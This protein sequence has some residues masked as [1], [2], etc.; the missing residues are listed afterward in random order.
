[1]VLKVSDLCAGYNGLSV[2]K[3][4]SLEVAQGESVALLGRNGSGKSTLL[5][6]LAGLHR[7]Y[8]GRVLYK[9]IDLEHQDIRERIRAGIVF[10]PQDLDI[11]PDMSVEENLKVCV[12]ELESLG[13]TA[14][15]ERAFQLCPNLQAKRS[16]RAG[17]LSGG[18]RRLMAIARA[19]ISSA[20][21][22]LLDEPSSG[23]APKALRETVS[24]IQQLRSNRCSIILVEQ[25]VD[26]ALEIADRVVVMEGGALH[27]DFPAARYRENS[28]EV[29]RLLLGHNVAKILPRGRVT[30]PKDKL[31]E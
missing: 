20:N 31:V 22:A 18:E 23:L 7:S 12:D 21:L 14:S 6:C 9:G 28:A 16:E 17:N 11:F 15:L 8:V 3:G 13:G 30:L 27:L 1:M 24:A 10:L 19:I 26:V 5:K 25:M 29:E 2:L 4:L